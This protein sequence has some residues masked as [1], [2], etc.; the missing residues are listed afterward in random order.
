MN[1]TYRVPGQR[2][3]YLRVSSAGQNLARQ[4][5]AVGE[6]DQTFTEKQSGKSATNRPQLQALI[7]HVRRGDHVVVAS[8]D[9]LGRS[10]IDLNDIVQQ[11]TGDPAEHTEQRPRKGASIEFLKERLT[12][13]PGEA[14]AMAAFQLNMMG[15][16]AQFERELIRQRQ[17]EGIAAAKKRGVYKGRPRVLDSEQVRSVRADVLAGTAKTDVARKHGISRSTLYRYIS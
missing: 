5:E 17:T 8:M 9:R 14:D 4:L 13:E 3:A 11:I 16:F 6:C 15:A 2:V 7:R 12:F 1:D 10:V